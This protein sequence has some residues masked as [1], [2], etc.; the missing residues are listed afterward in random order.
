V[1]RKEAVG[2]SFRKMQ[3]VWICKVETTVVSNGH[4]ANRAVTSFVNGKRHK[5]IREVNQLPV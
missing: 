1:K 5:G 3:N 2:T 4:P